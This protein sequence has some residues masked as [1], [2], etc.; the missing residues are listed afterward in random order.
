MGLC[1]VLLTNAQPE[2]DKYFR[3]VTAVH[4][5]MPCELPFPLLCLVGAEQVL[6]RAMGA[7]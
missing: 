7:L 2:A 5:C 3:A 6:D 4:V 1:Y